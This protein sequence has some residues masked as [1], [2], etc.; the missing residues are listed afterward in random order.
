MDRDNLLRFTA[1]FEDEKRKLYFNARILDEDLNISRDEMKDEI[2]FTST[3]MQ[4]AMKMRLRSRESLYL[5]KVNEALQR[6]KNG[7]FGECEDCGDQ[8]EIRRLNARPITTLCLGC[9]EEEE[10][11]EQVYIDGHGSKSLAKL[12]GVP[13]LA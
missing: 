9:K 4:Q 7:T 12:G 6:I 5:K 8:I 2:D 13:M 10:R 3:E 1:L 11:R